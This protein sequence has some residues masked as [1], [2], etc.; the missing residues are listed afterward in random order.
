MRMGKAL[1][2]IGPYKASQADALSW[3]RIHTRAA[4][5]AEANGHPVEA[6][7]H[8]RAALRMLPDEVVADLFRKDVAK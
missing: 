1:T 2:H 4:I 3:V 8:A 7:L 5:E 6:R